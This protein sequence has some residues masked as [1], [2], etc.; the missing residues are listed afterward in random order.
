MNL[1]RTRGV[2]LRIARGLTWG[3]VA[4]S[5]ALGAACPAWAVPPE[6]QQQLDEGFR[7]VLQ[8]PGD[9][10][11]NVSYAQKLV[12]AGDYEKAIASLERILITDPSQ[13]QVRVEIGALYFR[14]GSYETARVYFRRALEDPNLPPALRERSEQ[15]LKDIA[16]RLSPSQ[17]TGFASVGAR[18]QAN[19]NTGPS[20]TNLFSN[21]VPF[22]RPNTQQPQSDFSF[23]GAGKVQ[24][25]YDLDTQNEAQ[26]VSTLLGYGNAYS[27]F[28]R[29]DVTLGE[30][31]TGIRFKPLPA[32]LKDLQIRPHVIANDIEFGG[33][34]LLSTY[35]A[36]LDVT[37]T[38][39]ENLASELTLEYR[40]E[41]YGA[42]A[43]LGDTQHQTGDAKVIKLRT[44]YELTGNSLVIADLGYRSAAAQRG[45]YDYT[46]YSATLTYSLG[47][48]APA[49]LTA[50]AWTVAPYVG[51][52]SRA[53]AGLDP[54]SDPFLQRMD[55]SVRL[56]VIHTIPIADGWSTYQQVEHL[57][58]DSNIPNFTF[59]DTAVILG[60]TRT[61]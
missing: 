9:T 36:G 33:E 39:T 16:D 57:W 61:F 20:S 51:W 21:G 15:F 49:E 46:Q 54:F 7:Q 8:N 50:R 37:M 35:G 32:E 23:F 59:Q 45:Y 28:S 6:V 58:G 13:T 29:E 42:I 44:A 24:H 12:D 27:R 30:L 14:L 41:D 56:G 31:T 40:H 22:T 2:R 38:W 10:G 60:L 55:N 48:A 11:A 17:F 19:A 18:W 53:Y 52:Y 4:L 25:S 47:Y 1:S 26:I 43:S 34:R 3:G 5:S